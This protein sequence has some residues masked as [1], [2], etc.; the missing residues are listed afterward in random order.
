MPRMTGF[1]LIK[2]LREAPATKS[3]PVIIFSHLG[4]DEDRA[5]AQTLMVD[6]MVKGYDGPLKI[7]KLAQSLLDP[8]SP[9]APLP[10]ACRTGREGEGGAKWKKT[11]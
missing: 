4:R 6:F 3:L 10:P 9:P 8:A 2:K 5:K 1:E 11:K 7:L